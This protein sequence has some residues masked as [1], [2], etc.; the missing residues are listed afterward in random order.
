MR[1]GYV[2]ADGEAVGFVCLSVHHKNSGMFVAHDVKAH[3]PLPERTREACL[4]VV[5][6]FLLT[7][8]APQAAT[9]AARARNSQHRFRDQTRAEMGRFF[10]KKGSGAYQSPV[11]TL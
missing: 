6:D 9:G 2:V 4:P 3:A 11:A 7:S 8:R 5:N 1:E 10:A